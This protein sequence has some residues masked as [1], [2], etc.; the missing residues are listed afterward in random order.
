MRWTLMAAL[1]P[2]TSCGVS[3][4]EQRAL[5][6]PADADA[7]EKLGNAYRM[8]MRKS[9]AL[10]AYREALR[11]DPSRERLAAR[12]QGQPTKQAR[13]LRQQAIANPNDDELWGDLGDL[14]RY[15]GD[16]LGA[17]QAYMRAFRIDPADSEW[18]TALLDLGAGDMVLDV[19]QRTL[20]DDDDESLGDYGDLLNQMGRTEEACSHWERAMH[21]DPDDDEW[22]NHA[23]ECGYELPEGYTAPVYDT[24]M[25]HHGGAPQPSYSGLPTA[26]DIGGLVQ[27]VGSDAK[28]LVRLGQA[29]LVAKDATKAEETLWSALLVAP[30]DEEAIQSYLVATG[31][32][33]RQALENLR[34][35]FPDNDEVIGSLAD[36]YLDLGMRDRARDLYNLAHSLDDDDPE[37]KAKRDLLETAR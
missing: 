3:K 22:I 10:D 21:L 30:T 12:L 27:R 17:R 4:A 7:W 25:G 15:E 19:A 20:R 37:W 29:Y 26:D 28:L 33:R 23:E 34:N 1:L 5:A 14:L 2:L 8:R 18:H 24:G 11:I 13:D 9:R 16:T 35:T 32:T 36:H 6:S 31:Q